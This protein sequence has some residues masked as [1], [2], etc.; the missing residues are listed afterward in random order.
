MK[1]RI[2]LS[3]IATAI[4]VF[5]AFQGSTSLGIIALLLSPVIALVIF[6]VLLMDAAESPTYS[7]NSDDYINRRILEELKKGR[8]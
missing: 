7:R 8:K 4:I 6:I 3:L 2:V 1:L 5:V